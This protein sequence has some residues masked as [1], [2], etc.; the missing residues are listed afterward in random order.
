MISCCCIL[1]VAIQVEVA[2]TTCEIHS[3]LDPMFMC[4][5][6]HRQIFISHLYAHQL[7]YGEQ[8]I[9]ASMKI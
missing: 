5:E 1:L 7:I 9:F 3:F 2:A 6:K 8:L 4:I